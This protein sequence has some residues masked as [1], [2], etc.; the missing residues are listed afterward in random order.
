MPKKPQ[1]VRSKKKDSPKVRSKKT[2]KASPKVR[3]KK[4]RRAS[5]KARSKK[6]RRASPKTRSKK[7]AS[8]KARSKTT[9]R[10][11]PKTNAVRSKKK[12]VR[13][14]R[15]GSK[16]HKECKKKKISKIMGEYKRSILKTSAGRLVTNRKQA[17]AIALSSAD[18]KC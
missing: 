17:L 5:P 16:A 14:F 3:S 12:T 7:K 15:K 9:R 4:T 6:T 2:R 8:P 1:I 13:K 18:R 10:A 11:S